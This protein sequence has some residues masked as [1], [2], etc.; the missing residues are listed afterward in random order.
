VTQLPETLTGRLDELVNRLDASA[1]AAGRRRP[2]RTHGDSYMACCPAHDDH[3]PSLSIRLEGSRIL[4]HC[5]TGCATRDA[6]EAVG[7]PIEA[8]FDDYRGEQTT[9]PKI[10][11]NGSSRIAEDA[12]DPAAAGDFSLEAGRRMPPPPAIDA[13]LALDFPAIEPL[14]GPIATQQIVMLHAPPGVGK[15]M[16]QLAMSHALAGGTDFVGWVSSRRARVLVVDGEM[17]GQMMQARMKDIA[18]L[19][20]WLTVANIANWAVSN[21]YDPINLATEQGQAVV[22]LWAN[23]VGAEIIVLD[24][25]MSL[26]WLNGVSMS[27]DEYW[28]PVRRFCVSQRAKGRTVIVVDHSNAQGDIFG[29]KTKLWHADLAIALHAIDAP[30]EPLYGLETTV[31]R[32]RFSLRFSKVR[33]TPS[34]AGQDVDEKVITIG[35]VGQPWYHESGKEEKR[36]RARD[37]SKNGLSIRD[38]AEELGASK[39]AVGRW[40]KGA[41]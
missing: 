1:V 30:E 19:G 27:S 5:F 38:I 28:Q 17:A 16:L 39:S 4:L 13:F 32:T 40:I 7:M 14:L 3:D 18:Q 25:L 33:G 9:D 29:T 35:Q 24:N 23:M 2:R 26:A 6:C 37:M 31:P 21:G 11:W 10:C 12:I 8:L 34:E 36:R 20:D 15:T 22:D 41:K